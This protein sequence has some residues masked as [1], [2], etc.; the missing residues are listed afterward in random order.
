MPTPGQPGDG[1][2]TL[3]T[4]SPPFQGDQLGL[5]GPGRVVRQDIEPVPDVLQYNSFWRQL[6][7]FAGAAPNATIPEAETDQP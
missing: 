2:R 5:L 1:M 7:F 4:T 6:F 3:D